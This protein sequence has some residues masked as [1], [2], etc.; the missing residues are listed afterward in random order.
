MNTERPDDSPT[1]DEETGDTI[2]FDQQ[3]I[4]ETAEF[5]ALVE[6]GADLLD[7]GEKPETADAEPAEDDDLLSITD[8]FENLRL[9]EEEGSDPA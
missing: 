3:P 6:L 7:D 9:E 2:D 4:M 5:Q 8:Q 1:D